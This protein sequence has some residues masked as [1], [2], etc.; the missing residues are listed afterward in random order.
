MT[1]DA[2]PCAP[3][4]WTC[5]QDRVVEHEIGHAFGLHHRDATDNIM[6]RNADFS[7]YSATDWQRSHVQDM[8]DRLSRCHERGRL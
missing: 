8:A 1:S 6:H 3:F 4:I 2:D 5:G 7:D